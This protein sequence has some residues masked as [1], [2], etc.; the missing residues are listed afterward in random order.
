MTVLS[1]E[2]VAPHEARD[3]AP[4]RNIEAWIFDLDNTL[5]PR[6]VNLFGQVDGRIRTYLRRLLDVSEEEAE[7]LQRGF[8]RDHG[9]TLRGLMLERCVDVDE[10]LAFVHDVDHSVLTPDP[11]LGDAIAR[12]PGRKFIFTNGSRMHAERVAEQLGFPHHFEDIFDI[13]AA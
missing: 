4:F 13:V 8:Y 1:V 5:Y 6:E 10:F 7:R 11:P 9:T 2:K 3:L 12:L